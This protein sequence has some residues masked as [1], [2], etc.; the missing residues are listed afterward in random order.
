MKYSWL[1]VVV[2]KLIVTKKMD[3]AEAVKKIAAKH[4]MNFTELWNLI[5][6]FYK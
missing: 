2:I 1:V 6:D 5:P 3:S 4:G